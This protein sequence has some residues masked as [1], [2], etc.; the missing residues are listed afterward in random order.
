MTDNSG[1]LKLSATGLLLLLLAATM[2]LFADAGP[3]H[4][5]SA[6]SN[7]IYRGFVE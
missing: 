4:P 7:A 6:Q 2:L 5:S 3:P 1:D